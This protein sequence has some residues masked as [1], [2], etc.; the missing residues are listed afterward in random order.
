MR[1]LIAIFG[2]AALVFAGCSNPVENSVEP[3]IPVS[4][5]INK[6]IGF[7]TNTLTALPS[8]LYIEKQIDGK[9]GGKVILQGVYQNY[10]G[11]TVTVTATLEV[12]KDAYTGIKNI[13]MRTDQ[14]S[15]A[16]EFQPGGS[17]VKPLKLDLKFVGMK[18]SRYNLQ[19]GKTDF[20]YIADDGTMVVIKNDG[21]NINLKD[22]KAEVHGA[23]LNHFSRYGFIR[24]F[25][26]QCSSSSSL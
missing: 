15:P 9:L 25:S 13:S 4:G 26:Q 24:K 8:E 18:L 11:D 6:E 23:Q 16:M 10:Y 21:M 19:D 12:P 2:L 20:F 22:K 7:G 3:I 17:F 1:K 14:Y 5:S